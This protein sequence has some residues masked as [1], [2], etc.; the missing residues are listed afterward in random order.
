MIIKLV[1]RSCVDNMQYYDAIVYSNDKEFFL[2]DVYY[3]V[4]A[5]VWF[6]KFPNRPLF[7]TILFSDVIKYLTEY[8]RDV[9][10]R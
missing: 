3:N 1:S 6:V 8:L 4:H 9:F 10:Y 7:K 5:H 2:T